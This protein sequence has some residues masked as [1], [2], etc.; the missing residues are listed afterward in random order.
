[1]H[2]R[3][4]NTSFLHPTPTRRYATG[5]PVERWLHSLLC[6]DA[7]DH[8]AKLPQGQRLPHPDECELYVRGP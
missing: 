2:S 4:S 6:L 3:L 8:M 5:D 1:M 7:A